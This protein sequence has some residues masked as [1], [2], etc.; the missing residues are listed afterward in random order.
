[1]NVL[2]IAPIKKAFSAIL[3]NVTDIYGVVFV[4]KFSSLSI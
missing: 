2:R 3:F 1:M 4:E